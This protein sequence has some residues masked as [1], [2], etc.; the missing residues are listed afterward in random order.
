MVSVEEARKIITANISVLSSGVR[1]VDEALGC[2]L[3]EDVLSVVDI[4]G[5][6]QSAMDGYAIRYEDAALPLKLA[7]EMYAGISHQLSLN[8]GETIRVFTGAPVP[9]NADT[10]VMQEKIIKENSC[11]YI[12]DDKIKKG[13][14]IRWQGEEI[15][16]G[17][18]IAKTGSVLS[19]AVIGLF[20]G[21]GILKVK[22][23]KKPGVGL[24]VTGNELQQPGSALKYGQVYDANTFQLKAALQQAGI[25][26][27][28]VYHADDDIDDLM[29]VLRKSL[30]DNEVTILTGGVSVGD[31]D[32]VVKALS[33]LGVV[34]HFHKIKQKPGKPM[35]FGTK[36]NKTVFGLPGNP[37]SALI[38]FYIYVRPV[39][40]F[41]SGEKKFFSQEK[42]AKANTTFS[43]S[44]GITYFL[45]AEYKN[46]TV[47]ISDAQE[48][49]KLSS[50]ASANCLVELDA[51][52][53]EIAINDTVKIHFLK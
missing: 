10:V 47:S 19:P 27:I 5:F 25:S 33:K 12:H 44:P 22:V 46:E 50:F 48:S 28:N 16:S 3:A 2:I 21:A 43:K 32:Y 35:F 23:Y 7:G 4:P 26:L 29:Q 9:S 34:Q 37:A 6:D 36:D 41:L 45:K 39:I 42:W 15:K 52:Q 20:A 30:E 38:C 1:R 40:M 8:A 51:S 17:D 14:H 11:I 31:Y 13:L 24:I 49:H 18:L 53:S